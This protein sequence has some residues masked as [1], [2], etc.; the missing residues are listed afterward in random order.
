MKETRPLAN[1]NAFVSVRFLAE[2][3]LLVG[4]WGLRMLRKDEVRN[5]QSAGHGD[6]F[7]TQFLVEP[8]RG[9]DQTKV[10]PSAS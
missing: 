1:H 4:Y 5:R 10:T 3:T 9:G 2:K 8:Q 6:N 7:T